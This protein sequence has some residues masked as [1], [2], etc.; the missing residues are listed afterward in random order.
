MAYLLDALRSRKAVNIMSFEKPTGDELGEA[1]R[2]KA[3]CDKPIDLTDPDCP[4]AD[5]IDREFQE[6]FSSLM[7]KLNGP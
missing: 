6:L 5:F 2:L 7:M 3:L 1:E 4:P